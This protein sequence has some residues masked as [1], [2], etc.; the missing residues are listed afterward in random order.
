MKGMMMSAARSIRAHAKFHESRDVAL[1]TALRAVA[2]LYVG[3]AC[4]LPDNDLGAH[5]ALLGWASEVLQPLDR[6]PARDLRL[7]VQER[8]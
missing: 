4:A 3:R 8:A 1:A 2:N 6:N 7:M 5:L